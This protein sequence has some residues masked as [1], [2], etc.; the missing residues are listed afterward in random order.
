MTAAQLVVAADLAPHVAVALEYHLRR[1]R[2]QGVP[3]P[4]GLVDL[5]DWAVVVQ[6]GLSSPPPVPESDTGPVVLLLTLPSVAEQLGCSLSTVK[7]LI[8]DGDLPTVR[9]AGVRRV[10]RVDLEEYVDRLGGSFR[11]RLEQKE[12]A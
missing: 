11:D 12:T 6:R 4:D 10:R 8:A 3:V 7:R 2:E 5:R 9:L 1:C